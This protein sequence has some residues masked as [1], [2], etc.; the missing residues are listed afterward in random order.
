MTTS[1]IRW[2]ALRVTRSKEGDVKASDVLGTLAAPDAA[3]ARQRAAALYGPTDLSIV[4]QLSYDMSLEEE[5]RLAKRRGLTLREL[6]NNE[7][8]RRSPVKK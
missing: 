2:V 8:T 7:R 5:R 6:F 1:S 3:T 4:S